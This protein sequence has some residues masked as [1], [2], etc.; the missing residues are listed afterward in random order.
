MF[1]CLAQESKI[2]LG[3]I[4]TTQVLVRERFG[5]IP[6]DLTHDVYCLLLLW[7][8]NLTEEVT[9]FFDSIYGWFGMY[10]EM[11]IMKWLS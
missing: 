6:E 2:Y 4:L 9:L 7:N 11:N 8:F 3:K 10:D 5:A 1:H